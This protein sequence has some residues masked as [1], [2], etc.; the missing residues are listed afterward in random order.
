[1]PKKS[2]SKI[3]VVVDGYVVQAVYV[4]KDMKL[5]SVVLLDGDNAE[6]EGLSSEVW[7]DYVNKKIKGMVQIF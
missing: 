2:D 7:E 6:A 1:M 5:S 3:A 4:T